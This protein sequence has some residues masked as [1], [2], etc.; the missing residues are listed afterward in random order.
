MGNAVINIPKGELSL[1]VESEKAIFNVF[2]SLKD[3][4]KYESCYEIITVDTSV[5]NPLKVT[6]H[7]KEPNKA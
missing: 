2:R 3:P 1:E 5:K 7:P 6:K 4:S